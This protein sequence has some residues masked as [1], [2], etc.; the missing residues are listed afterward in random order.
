MLHIL[1]EQW[2]EVT[3][4]RYPASLQSSEAEFLSQF[5]PVAELIVVTGQAP[6]AEFKQQMQAVMPEDL[7]DLQVIV[8]E[9]AGYH[10]QKHLGA[11]QATGDILLFLD[12]DVIPDS[13]WLA[14]LLSTFA[15]ARRSGRFRATLREAAG[16]LRHRV[17]SRLDLR[18]AG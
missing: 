13:G 10:A 8:S 1:A 11:Q 6:D 3:S 14:F 9:G 16:H 12:S 18:A 17:F 7:F 4:K 15:A 2:Q 5:D